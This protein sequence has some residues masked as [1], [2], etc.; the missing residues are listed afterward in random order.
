MVA[1]SVRTPEPVLTSRPLL[2]VTAPAR[3]RLPPE[4]SNVPVA[5][6]LMLLVHVCAQFPK[7]ANVPL[8]IVS[9][10]VTVLLLPSWT[11]P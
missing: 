3:V 2:L 9:R 6:R 10:P 7:I 11:V 4:V 1:A 5:C 8:L